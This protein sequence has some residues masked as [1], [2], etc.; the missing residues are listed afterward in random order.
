MHPEHSRPTQVPV[1][2]FEVLPPTP[3]SAMQQELIDSEHPT[4]PNVASAH[5]I[6]PV[7]RRM[8]EAQTHSPTSVIAASEAVPTSHAVPIS[9]AIPTSHA[10]SASQAVP[11]SHAVTTGQ[12]APPNQAAPPSQ[13]APTKQAV[14][15]AE[16]PHNSSFYSATHSSIVST[17]CNEHAHVFCRT[18]SI[19]LTSWC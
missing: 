17:T 2:V 1:V 16:L 19:H 15:V 3:S 4:T 13:A 18:T 10:L 14:P 12:A 5:D 9:H 8:S 6:T 7:I 11:T